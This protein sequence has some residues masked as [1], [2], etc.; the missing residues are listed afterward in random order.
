MSARTPATR[1]SPAHLHTGA[2]GDHLVLDVR[3]EAEFAAG[4]LPGA[5]NTPLDRLDE[6]LA[7]LEVQLAER[8]VVLVCRSG[9]RAQRAAEA[10]AGSGARSLKVL[11]GGLE[12]VSTTSATA[13]SSS[14]SSIG[15]STP[16]S[17]AG[18]GME[19]QVRL[20][21]G[22]IVATSILAS[23]WKPKARFVAGGIGAGLTVA[24]LSNTCAMGAALE[25]LPFNRPRAPRS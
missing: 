3:S 6:A 22:G 14:P 2:L 11:D 24:A 8:D 20:V 17:E 23:I 7:A 1:I 15:W 25:R 21:A 10:L 12:A 13:S 9:V 4:S 5:R 16:A 18:W 19:R